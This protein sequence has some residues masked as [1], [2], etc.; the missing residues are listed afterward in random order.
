MVKDA[1]QL[2]GIKAAAGHI[3][4]IVPQTI[5]D[6]VAKFKDVVPKILGVTPLNAGFFKLERMCAEQATK[7]RSTKRRKLRGK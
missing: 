2:V 6:R 4:R 7:Q 1:D 3:R 5:A